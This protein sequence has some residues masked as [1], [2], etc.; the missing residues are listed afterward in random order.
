TPLNAVIGMCGLLLDTE[1][2]KDQREFAET[3]KNGGETLLTLINDILDF[4]KIE[5]GRLELE[6]QPFDLRDC[7]ESALDLLAGRA[8][9]KGLDLLYWIDDDVPPAIVGDITRLR[10]VIVNLLSN[11][12]KFTQQGE[13]FVSVELVAPE[14]SG[15]VRLKISVRD[16]GIGIP[17]DR[18]D[19]LFK[20]FSQVDASTTRHF[21]GT[22]LGLCISKRLTELMGGT[23]AVESE[24]GR[25]SNFFFEIVAGPA[26][27]QKKLFQRGRSA[28]VAGRRVLIVDD[29]ATNRRLLALQTEGWGI[30]PRV[31]AGPHAAL[32]CLEGGE[33]FDAAILDMQMPGM[34]GVE[35]AGQIRTRWPKFKLPVILL[36]SLGDIGKHP[37]GGR[38]A[39]TLTKPV[40]PAALLE[41]LRSVL[42]G[43][44]RVEPQAAVVVS[45]KMAAK[46]PL[47][48][49]VAEDNPIN[50]KVARL[51]L[52][53][54]GY[55]ADLA[56]N[57]RE[58]VDLVSKNRYDVVF[59]DIQMPVLDG[60]AAAVEIRSRCPRA[61]DRPRLVAM[62]ANAMSGDRERCLEGGMDDYVAKPIRIDH[63]RGALERVLAERPAPEAAGGDACEGPIFDPSTIIAMLSDDPVESAELARQL[64]DSYFVDDAPTRF[65]KIVG[66]IRKDDAITAARESHSLKG[67]S[68]T[69]GM[70][71]VATVC[72]GIEQAAKAGDIAKATIVSQELAASIQAARFA[73]DDWFADRFE[74][75]AK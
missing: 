7:V 70:P 19:R 49:L 56:V 74:A 21:G 51:M 26:P 54:L 61:S 64:G 66:A 38:I 59:M 8:A 31:V 32:K 3:I 68:G 9:D 17:A 16:T 20:S 46:S 65:E 28:G 35:L 69:L 50:Q 37:E 45:D 25:G 15:S 55:T 33:R 40:K 6:Q 22:G 63:I 36:T 30:E 13:V 14:A 75:A 4:S 12:V 71:R 58:A 41:T 48:I 72:N 60:L 23:I 27:A 29:N 1:L 24:E 2:G 47:R 34:N 73:F 5:S 62:T 18:M 10:Q 42:A 52:S 67:A 39:A 11:A 57:G 53:Q 43:S 44:E